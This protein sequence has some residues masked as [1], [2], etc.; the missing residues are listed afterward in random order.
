MMYAILNK[1]SMHSSN[2][3][4]YYFA[5]PFMTL[6]D[7]CVLNDMLT[8]SCTSCF[9]FQSFYD[10]FEDVYAQHFF[11]DDCIW[12]IQTNRQNEINFFTLKL[13]TFDCNKPYKEIKK[14]IKIIKTQNKSHFVRFVLSHGRTWKLLRIDRIC[15]VTRNS[16]LEREVERVRDRE[17]CRWRAQLRKKCLKKLNPLDRNAA[18]SIDFLFSLSS[19]SFECVLHI[20]L[21]HTK[22]NRQ[23]M[24]QLVE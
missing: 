18:R 5:I 1:I 3:R 7:C 13:F 12:N 8:F 24:E 16:I 4:I 17:R 6:T 20:A 9:E 15:L 22:T 23:R 2:I 21:N 11:I 14:K 19:F 10:L